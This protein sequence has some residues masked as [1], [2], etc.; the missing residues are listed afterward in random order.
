MEKNDIKVEVENGVLSIS[1]ERKPKKW[2]KT[3]TIITTSNA[4]TGRL[5]GPS[6]CRKTS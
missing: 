1:G 2:K 4:R 6:G 5:T 3:K